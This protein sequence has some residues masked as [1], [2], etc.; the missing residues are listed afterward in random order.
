MAEDK[1][2]GLAGVIAGRTGI[3]TVEKEGTGLSYRG[4]SIYDLAARSTFEEVAY[5]LIY[6]RLP[7]QSLLSNYKKTLAGLR[8]LPAPL[9][10][11]LEQIPKST[12]PMDAMR[13]GCSM[14]GTLELE[15]TDHD[16]IAAANRLTSCF[17]SIL[18]YWHHFASGGNRI[19][20]ETDDDS[21]AG[22]SSICYTGKSLTS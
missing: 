20:T 6:G 4:Y 15:G 2:G 19:D 17:S 7:T 1:S 12:H 21:T 22:H 10:T 18:L 5:L 11:V 13:T 16:Q 3:A 8:G 14:L 9:R